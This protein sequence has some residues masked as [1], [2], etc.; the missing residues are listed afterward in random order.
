MPQYWEACV[1]VTLAA[2][3]LGAVLTLLSLCCCGCSSRP[4]SRSVVLFLAGLGG[5]AVTAAFPLQQ[6]AF[7]TKVACTAVTPGPA[8]DPA[9]PLRVTFYG[10]YDIPMLAGCT[11]IILSMMLRWC[12]WGADPHHDGIGGGAA[13]SEGEGVTLLV[14]N[15][16]G[17]VG[18][19][20]LL[21]G[22]YGSAASTS[23]AA[24][25]GNGRAGTSGGAAGVY[26][27][28]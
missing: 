20:P 5:A 13:A 1:A 26:V 24:A 2:A 15:P 16:V 23:Y 25:G 21:S 27:W 17:P 4:V 6:L 9:A 22:A 28:K 18:A 8:D 3:L 19:A 12:A 7:T 14:V 10:S 11:L